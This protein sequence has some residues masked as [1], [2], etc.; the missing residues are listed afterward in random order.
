MTDAPVGTLLFMGGTGARP[1][2]IVRWFRLYG[3][4]GR[5]GRAAKS[6]H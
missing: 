5:H 4:G 2:F 1:F 3:P 6:A